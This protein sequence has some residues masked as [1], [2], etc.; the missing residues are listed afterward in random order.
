MWSGYFWFFPVKLVGEI[1]GRVS[2]MEMTSEEGKNPI[3]LLRK[4]FV[5]RP[6][7]ANLYIDDIG[8]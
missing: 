2:I 8:K 1:G 6:Y 3:D 7:L 4:P 5:G